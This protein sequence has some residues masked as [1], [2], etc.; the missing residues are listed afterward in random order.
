MKKFLLPLLAISIISCS[1][2]HVVNVYSETDNKNTNISSIQNNKIEL[3]T[4]GNEI[5]PQI[6]NIIDGAQK[7]VYVSTY[8]FG[9]ALGQKIAEKLVAKK[10]QGVEVQ[11]VAEGSMG[12]IPELTSAAKKVYKYM[13]DN[14]LEVRVFPVDLMPKGP[15]FLSNK[16]VINHSKLVIAD[17][18]VAMIGGMNFKDSESVNRD[19]MLKISGDKVKELSTITDTD[20]EKSRKMKFNFVKD[21]TLNTNELEFAQTGFTV[22]NIDE[23]II[24][25][26]NNAKTSIDIEMLLIDYEDIVKALLD[27]KKRGVN[28]RIIVDQA[29]LAKYNKWL[30]KLPIEGMANF[31]AALTLIQG[32]IPLKW[33]VPQ[34]KDQVLHAKA[35][36]IDKKIFLTGSANMTYHAFTRNHEVYVAV[37]SPDVAQ[38][39]MY[40]F[41]ED[42]KNNSK[43]VELTNTQKMLGKLFQRFSKWIYTKTEDQF[44]NDIPNLRQMLNDVKD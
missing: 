7:K 41:E 14:G 35:I 23:M 28:V 10:K 43:N 31:G 32:G 5:F 2:N 9:G 29:D 22:Q 15:N 36:L 16:K 24:K 17:D 4:N 12:T 38:R 11:F 44:L 39:F 13:A 1:Q 40:T 25:H 26:I 37:N 27:A 20:W 34:S 3:Y 19:F 18:N 6:F 8:L 33:F 30:E 42:W 21:S